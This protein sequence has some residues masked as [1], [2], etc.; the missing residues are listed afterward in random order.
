M[1]YRQLQKKI[2]L[3]AGVFS[4]LSLGLGLALVGNRAAYAYGL[5]FGSII[6]IL[7]FLQTANAMA[8]SM[9]MP[10]HGAQK[11]I[12]SRYAIRMVIYGLVLFVSIR[13]DHINV[14]GTIIGFMSVK[15]GVMYLTIFKKM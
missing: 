5:A 6:S 11:Y 3:T 13:A 10:P 1:D 8:K 14:L 12:A 9:D 4:L 15:A 7:M 2:M